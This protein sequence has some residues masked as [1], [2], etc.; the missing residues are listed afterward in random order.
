MANH[1]VQAGLFIETLDLYLSDDIAV[2]QPPTEYIFASCPNTPRTIQLA[3][4]STH[5]Q[6]FIKYAEISALIGWI[7]SK[8][9]Q[10]HF[11][12]G[13]RAADTTDTVITASIERVDRD[14]SAR[15]YSHTSRSVQSM[16]GLQM[17][18]ACN[19]QFSNNR[20][21][22]SLSLLIMTF[23]LISCGILS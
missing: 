16:I 1:M 14:F 3:A 12:S 17:R 11:A 20:R 13:H 7:T 19:L 4:C 21:L 18:F 15:I 5:F 23:L 8:L 10:P 9:T 22:S 2:L 6:H